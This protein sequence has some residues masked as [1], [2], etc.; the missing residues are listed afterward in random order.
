[1]PMETQKIRV[2]H[3]AQCPL[4][5]SSLEPNSQ[6]FLRY[7]YRRKEVTEIT[8]EMNGLDTKKKKEKKRKIKRTNAIKPGFLK[9]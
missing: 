7:V 9:L 8:K 4:Y 1:M 3:L 2:T 6:N 5:C